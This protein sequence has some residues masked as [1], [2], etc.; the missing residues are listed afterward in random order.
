MSPQRNRQFPD[1]QVG[2]PTEELYN[3]QPCA[4][5]DNISLMEAI[6][7]VEQLGW[8]QSDAIQNTFR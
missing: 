7:T 3:K 1:D 2:T 4:I 5:D 6:R 8:V